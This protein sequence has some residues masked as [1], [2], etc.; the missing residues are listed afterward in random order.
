MPRLN[1]LEET[2]FEKLPITVYADKFAAST[3]VAKRIA[4]IITAKAAKGEMAVLGLATGVTPIAVYDELVRLHKEEQLSFKNVITFNL[5]EYYPMDAA[6][7]QSYNVF[8][9][10]HLF[11]HVDIN[12]HNVHIPNGSLGLDDIAGFCLAYEQKISALGGLVISGSMSRV[13]HQ[14]LVRVWF[15]WMSLHV[16]MLPMILA[17]KPMSHQRPS[18][19][20]LAPYLKHAKLF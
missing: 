6:A 14:T 5:D 13:P 4:D 2:R 7:V 17:E 10:Q 11:T 12:Q 1:L 19:W 18:P 9:H 16:M 20:E 15:R 3:A 8:M